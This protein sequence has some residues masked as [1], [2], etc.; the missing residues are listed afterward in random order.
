LA[1]RDDFPGRSTIE[2]MLGEYDDRRRAGLFL[3]TSGI[4]GRKFLSLVF[5]RNFEFREVCG[6]GAAEGDIGSLGGAC[7]LKRRIMCGIGPFILRIRFHS[8]LVNGVGSRLN[9]KEFSC[10]E[11][12][13]KSWIERTT[14]QCSGGRVSI[15]LK[16]NRNSRSGAISVIKTKK[17]AKMG[18]EQSPCGAFKVSN[19]K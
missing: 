4:V 19:L 17:R 13:W 8:R 16:G 9:W 7:L 2:P 14:V 3:G 5:C 18:I 12:R 1:G 6:E 15:A 11:R 10:Y